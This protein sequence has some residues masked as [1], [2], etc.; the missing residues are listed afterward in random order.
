MNTPIHFSR[1][2]RLSRK[3]LLSCVA[4]LA[5]STVVSGQIEP[6]SPALEVTR[7]NDNQP[8]ITKKMF[9]DI[10][11]GLERDG[12]NINGPCLVRIPDWVDPENRADVSAVYYLYFAHHGDEYIRMAWA[13]NI[14]GPY[15]LYNTHP[16]GKDND[17]QRGRGVLDLGGH[18]GK[19]GKPE[20]KITKD[21]VLKNNVASPDVIIDDANRR[22]VLFFHAHSHKPNY[23]SRVANTSK[24]KTFVATSGTGL[25]FNMPDG[26]AVLQG[27]VD[28]GEVGHGIKTAYLGNAYF[29]TFQYQGE[30]FAFTNYGPI[31]KAPSATA[32]WDTSHLEDLKDDAW[33][34][35][36]DKTENPVM[37]DIR[38]YRTIHEAE[39]IPGFTRSTTGSPRHFATLLQENGNILEVWYTSRGDVPER[40]FRTTM[41]LSQDD[42]Q[43]WDTVICSKE[44]IHQE[45][46]RPEHTWEGCDL[47]VKGSSNGQTGFSH[48]MRDPDLFRDSDGKV[49]LLYVGGGESAI[50]IARVHHG[51]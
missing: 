40:I 30:M 1:L 4:V 12:G 39:A 46:L 7:L 38:N 11:T 28:G 50:G 27:G 45:M 17:Q 18:I 43:T 29:R 44:D 26:S 6:L 5:A 36:K 31:W 8:I 23:D 20:I 19:S 35:Q 49:Y 47:P 25:N 48:A 37:V 9:L 32:P 10:D 21:I 22:F 33:Q 14:G 24:Q 16:K 41:D 3:L 13:V 15:T 51:R 2:I 42:W 34:E